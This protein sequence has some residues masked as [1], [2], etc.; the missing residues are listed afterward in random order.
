M[1]KIYGDLQVPGRLDKLF[2][3]G[4]RTCFAVPGFDIRASWDGRDSANGAPIVS[5]VYP[6]QR[7]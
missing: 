2:L 3:G 5:D 6:S 4:G 7:C 1:H